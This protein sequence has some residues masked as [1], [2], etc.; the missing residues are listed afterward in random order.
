MFKKIIVAYDGSEHSQRA[1]DY[2]VMLARQFES[3]VWVVHAFAHTLDL[4][5]RD[6]YER[7]VSNREAAGQS[8]L[9]KARSQLGDTSLDIR[10]EL[11]EGP[12]P[13][14]FWPWPKPV[15]QG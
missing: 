15:T 14:Q 11:I 7:L 4:L 1:L 10:E 8:V 13:K 9:N 12:K 6:E 3:T 5:S 2:A